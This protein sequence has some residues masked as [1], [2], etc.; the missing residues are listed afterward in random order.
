MD[1]A[2]R[3]TESHNLCAQLSGL[4]AGIGGNIAAA[5]DDNGLALKGLA[6]IFEHGVGEVAHAEAG[7]LGAGKG[8]AVGDALAGD[9]AAFIGA[10]DALE[11]AEEVAHL[12]GAHADIAGGNVN[13]LSH[14]FVKLRHEALA[15][16]HDLGIGFALGVEVAAA[17]AAADGQAGEGVFEDLFKAQELDGA[18]LNAG[19]EAQTAL[20]GADGGIELNAEAAVYMDL[21]RVVGPGDPEL[22]HA[23]GLGEALDETQLFILGVLLYNGLQRLQ[24]LVNGLEKLLLAL[25]AGLDLGN[26]SFQI[27]VFHVSP[28]LLAV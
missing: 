12:A 26:N 6:V 7:G 16:A 23:L 18:F 4:H 17:L 5:G 2:V 13:V 24:H 10:G 11:L 22:Y 1:I 27:F 8:A 9:D 19:M 3:V 15:E 28:L 20:V 21:A 25:V 14:I